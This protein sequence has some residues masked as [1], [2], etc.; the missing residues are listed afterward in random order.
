LKKAQNHTE[1]NALYARVKPRIARLS[2]FPESIWSTVQ[3]AY[4][5]ESTKRSR[6]PSNSHPC[7]TLVTYAPVVDSKPKR[8]ANNCLHNHEE[9]CGHVK[10]SWTGTFYT[11]V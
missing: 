4:T 11:D 3:P 10:R 9:M 1:R 6:S 8:Y 2:C 7:R 5:P